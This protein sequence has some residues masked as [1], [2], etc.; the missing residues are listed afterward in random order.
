M[1]LRV[2]VYVLFIA[3]LGGSIVGCRHI[4]YEDPH[5]FFVKD[6]TMDDVLHAAVRH[7]C[8]PQLLVDDT[9]V[10]CTSVQNPEKMLV[11]ITLTE[12]K[13][14]NT[15]QVQVEITNVSRFKTEIENYNK[16]VK[17]H[18]KKEKKYDELKKSKNLTEDQKKMKKEALD[19][20]D[21]ELDALSNELDALKETITKE[22]PDTEKYNDWI[23]AFE[24]EIRATTKR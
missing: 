14:N 13:T 15:I 5:P 16:K 2:I 12:I 22:F 21:N 18:D 19:A 10:K 3:A 20:L 23:R 8:L 1:N 24:N 4:C 11:E 9:K 7:K 6:I 17:E